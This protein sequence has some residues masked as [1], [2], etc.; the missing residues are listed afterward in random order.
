MFFAPM[1]ALANSHPQMGIHANCFCSFSGSSI[2][3]SMFL[4]MSLLF[5][6][7]KQTD[8][9]IHFLRKILGRGESH[10]AFWHRLTEKDVMSLPTT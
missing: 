3:S 8:F 9:N 4:G 5:P 1:K 6:L 7:R 2:L 10:D